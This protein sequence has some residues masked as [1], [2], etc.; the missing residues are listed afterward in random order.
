M[1]RLLW[2]IP[3][4]CTVPPPPAGPCVQ[5]NTGP[6]GVLWPTRASSAGVVRAGSTRDCGPCRNHDSSVPFWPLLF[7]PTFSLGPSEGQ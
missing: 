7:S 1:E 4:L 3:C 2:V 5:H 6:L